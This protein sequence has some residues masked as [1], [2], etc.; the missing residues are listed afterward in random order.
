MNSDLLATIQQIARNELRR[1][2]TAELA[3]VQALFPH[4]DEGDKDNYGL[5]V[6]LRNSG[7]VLEKVPLLTGLPG[8]AAIPPVGALVLVQFLGGDLNRPVVTG[9]FYNDEDRPPANDDGLAVCHLPL[10]AADDE[11]VHLELES[12]AKRRLQL[13][14]G[15]GLEL[16]L[17]DDD[18]TV[19]LKVGDGKAT[20]TIAADGAVTLETQGELAIQAGELGVKAKKIQ[21]EAD[22]ELNLK[23][24]LIN[25]N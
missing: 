11:A 14:L 4:A 22:G 8:L 9:C 21:I 18:P 16:L 25:L 12:A 10:A 17:Q 20:L 13:K 5:T 15:K 7:L 1:L 23:G 24:S 2:C 3:V 6:Q 19:Q